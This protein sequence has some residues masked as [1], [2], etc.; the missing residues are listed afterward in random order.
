MCAFAGWHRALGLDGRKIAVSGGVGT[1]SASENFG[2]DY[3]LNP[4]AYLETCAAIGNAFFSAEMAS[5][6]GDAKYMMSFERVS[7]MHFWSSFEDGVHYTYPNPLTPKGERWDW[8]GVPCC[9][10]MFIK[11]PARF[12]ATSMR[13]DGADI[14]E[15]FHRK[16][17][18][19]D[20]AS[21]GRVTL[22]QKTQLSE[23]RGGRADGQPRT[24]RRVH[25]AGRIP[26][27]AARRESVRALPQ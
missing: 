19:V 18:F 21:A 16:Q 7:T 11:S 3:E 4:D 6:T 10:P 24:V 26:G 27:G 5:L 14:R 15:S 9:P 25:I 20:D 2:G 22:V 23:A 17:D 12:T 1:E 13:A 8:H